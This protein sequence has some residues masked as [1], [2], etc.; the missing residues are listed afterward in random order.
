MQ[1]QYIVDA[2]VK[3]TNIPSTCTSATNPGDII[4]FSCVLFENVK[5]AEQFDVLVNGFMMQF[6]V[7][8]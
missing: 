4:V 7:R 5:N 6:F 8:L 1:H 3:Q 2:T